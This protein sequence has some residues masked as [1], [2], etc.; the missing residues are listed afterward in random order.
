MGRYS[1]RAHWKNLSW[2]WKE[3]YGR[4]WNHLLQR[5]EGENE[6]GGEESKKDR[7]EG[8]VEP[9]G[10]ADTVLWILWAG[11]NLILYSVFTK[12]QLEENTVKAEMDHLGK[13]LEKRRSKGYW[14][15]H[16]SR[17]T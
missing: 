15:S 2:T 9:D 5:L 4:L 3:R 8:H 17:Y 1:E 14:N 16:Q 10:E 6:Y 7:T 11:M 13:I 12:F